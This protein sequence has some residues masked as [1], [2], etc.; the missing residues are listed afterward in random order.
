MMEIKIMPVG[1]IGTNCY[2]ISNNNQALIVDPGGDADQ[3]IEYIEEKALTPQAII[4]THAHFDHI[5]GLEDLRN[6]YPIETYINE[7]E[8][9]WLGDPLLNGSHKLLGNEITARPAENVLEEGEL[10]IGGFTFDVLHTPGHSPGSVSFIFAETNEIF[11]GD[12]LF[13]QGIGRTDLPGGD[14]ATLEHSIKEK[15]YLFDDDYKIYPGHGPATTIGFEK[16]NNPFF[17]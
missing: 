7:T 5:G 3:I 4:L 2:I 9:S 13:N 12:V 1:L 16:N 14:L 10:S 6:K 8:Q 17:R 11:S 15:L